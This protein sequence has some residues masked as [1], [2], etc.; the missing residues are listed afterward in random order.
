MIQSFRFKQPNMA[1][2]GGDEMKKHSIW[3]HLI[4]MP[5]PVMVIGIPL[6]ISLAWTFG[7][8]YFQLGV[9]NTMTSVLFVILFG[10]SIDYGLHYYARYIELRSEDRKSVV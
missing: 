2:N 5:V 8:T 4:R 9:L 7:L 10:L 3:S 1:R 6:L